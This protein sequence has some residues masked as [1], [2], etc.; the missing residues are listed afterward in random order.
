MAC[1]PS[2]DLD[3]PGH[4]NLR[5]ELNEKL[6][7]I[8][9]FVRTAKTLVRLGGCPRLIW[10]FAGR[11]CHFV[12]FS[13]VGSFQIFL[14]EANVRELDAIDEEDFEIFS[15]TP[16][17]DAY[18]ELDD[19]E[20][21]SRE[22]RGS[23]VSSISEEVPDADYDT[24]LEMEDPESKFTVFTLSIRTPWFLANNPKL[25]ARPFYHLVLASSCARWVANNVDPDQTPRLG[26]LIWVYTVCSSLNPNT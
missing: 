24:D 16:L 10:V 6:R 26:R 12:G 18:E 25:W 5:C 4:Q 11:T 8:A 20:Y 14:T 17:R 1:A 9:F 3:Q 2:E 22:T 15:E 21:K 19:V 7:T 23:N 13:R